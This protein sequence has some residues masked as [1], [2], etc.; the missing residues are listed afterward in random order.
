MV[1]AESPEQ[2]VQ[3]FKDATA[4]DTAPPEYK[5]EVDSVELIEEDISEDITSMDEY[6]DN[7]KKR[8]L[9]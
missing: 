7:N 4:L 3:K 5:A 8:V 6:I 9:N 1:I 2:A